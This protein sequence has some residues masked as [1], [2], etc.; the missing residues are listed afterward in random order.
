MTTRTILT[1]L[2]TLIVLLDRKHHPARREEMNLTGWAVAM[3][4]GCYQ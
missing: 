2:W 3:I 4:V 1:L